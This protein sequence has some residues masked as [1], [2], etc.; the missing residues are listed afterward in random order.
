MPNKFDKLAKEA[1]QM[2]DEH[3]ESK[4]SS[5]TSLNDAETE[6]IINDSGISKQDLAKVLQEVK[7]ASSSNE[8]KAQAIQ[9]IDKGVS[10][11]V[12]IVKKLI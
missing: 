1:A 7:N 11:L 10:A 6:K 3:F 8:A 2:A 9:N 12:S 4:F 5:L